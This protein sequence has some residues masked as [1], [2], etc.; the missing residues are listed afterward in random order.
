MREIGTHEIWAMKARGK[1]GDSSKKNNI[2]VSLGQDG[3]G[4]GIT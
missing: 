4:P 3:G 2:G 1:E